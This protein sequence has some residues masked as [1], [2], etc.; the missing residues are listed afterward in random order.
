MVEEGQDLK[1]EEML[2]LMF[3]GRGKGWACY[4]FTDELVVWPPNF[5]K[6]VQDNGSGLLVCKYPCV[7]GWFI[8]RTGGDDDPVTTY[9]E[10]GPFPTLRTAMAVLKICS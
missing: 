7:R 4:W 9:P 10:A 1:A 6:T 2:Q 5:Y 3:E 8:A